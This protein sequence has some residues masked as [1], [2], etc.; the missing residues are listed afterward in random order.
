MELWTFATYVPHPSKL[1]GKIPY[2]I[3]IIPH[4]K[5][6]D[7]GGEQAVRI[8]IQQWRFDD[9]P[10]IVA[11]SGFGSLTLAEDI[12][13]WSGYSTL[14]ISVIEASFATLLSQNL[15]L[16]NWHACIKDGIIHS[17]QTKKC[18]NSNE[19]TSITKK[20]VIS[21]GFKAVPLEFG[22]V[23]ITNNDQGNIYIFN[24]LMN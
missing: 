12:R 17:V 20:F 23:A 9:K 24:V 18:E 19:S 2:F 8:M 6:N 5:L 1:N 13:S 22:T 21:T 7:G 4:L 14:S 3:E 16:N 11:D 15:P 10:C